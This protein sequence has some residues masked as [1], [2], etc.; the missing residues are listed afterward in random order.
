MQNEVQT[1]TSMVKGTFE[2]PNV[3]NEPGELVVASNGD[4]VVGNRFWTVFCK[5]V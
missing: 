3:S 1:G 2:S 5:E 4:L